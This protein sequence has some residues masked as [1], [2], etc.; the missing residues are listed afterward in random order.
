MTD[1]RVET[2]VRALND[3]HHEMLG[4]ADALKG[5]ADSCELLSQTQRNGWIGH[6]EQMI[7]SVSHR[8]SNAAG[9]IESLLDVAMKDKVAKHEEA[10]D[11]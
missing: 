2:L 8:I 9:E 5:I 10:H 1:T 6:L 11:G 4:S 7:V 3:L